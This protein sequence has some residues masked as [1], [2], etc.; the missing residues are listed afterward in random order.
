M[1]NIKFAATSPQTIQFCRT[2]VSKKSY[3]K[4]CSGES[5]SGRCYHGTA[6]NNPGAR[7]EGDIREVFK[8]SKTQLLREAR[9]LVTPA[10]KKVQANEKSGVKPAQKAKKSAPKKTSSVKKQT[11]SVTKKSPVKKPSAKNSKATKVANKK[12]A[13]KKVSK[14]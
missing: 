14:K 13:G 11:S 3:R 5:L 1:I 8:N 12:P 10:V 9:A 7:G 6:L 2:R 4:A